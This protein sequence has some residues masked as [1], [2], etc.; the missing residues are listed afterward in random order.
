MI[1]SLLCARNALLTFASQTLKQHPKRVTSA[2]AAL[3]L[4]GGGGAFALAS[5]APDA[6]ELPVREVL[7][8][9]QALPL[10][11]ASD[12]LDVQAFK[13][14]RSEVTRSSDTADTLLKRLGVDDEAAA[15]FLR[16]DATARQVLLGRSGRNVTAET[17]E[18]NSLLK[19]SARWSAD[20]DG[21]FKRLVVEKTPQGF[22]S[23]IESAPL[24]ASTRLASGT[25]QTSLFAA[26]DDA[27]IPD[28][29]ATQVTEI[30]SGDID[31]HRSLRKGDR[32]SVV[33]E[34]LEG[35]GEPLR[36]GRVLS[37]EFVNGGKTFQAMWFQDPVAGSTPAADGA[38]AAD[39]RSK[40][41]YYTLDG[42]SLRRA[43]LA[44]P[45][46]FSRITSGFKMRF[47][48]LLH[49]W[50]AHQ[51]V[52]YAAPTGTAVRSVGDGVVDF[53]GVQNGYGNV[54]IL[55]HRNNYKTV[56]A[57]LS[58]INVHKGESVSQGQ[59]I[60]AVGATGWATG[61]HLH[62]EY[63]INNVYH[64]PLTIARE[65]NTVP[66]SASAKPAFARLASENR[67]ALSAA[68]TLQQTSA[69]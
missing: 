6:S 9:V 60:G 44:S 48:P 69:Q 52:D 68:A 3:L 51:G 64:D 61:P 47:H 4:G 56:Y 33:Y 53:A 43:Y 62:F 13:L 5:Y 45:V 2:I 63:R 24:S 17:S 29:I 54:I 11:V 28:S 12:A 19:L 35:D 50:K 30:F 49:V 14:F 20:S 67:V 7:E 36:T 38:S 46:E 41:G 42:Q 10:N 15:S 1:N 40:G 57:H 66:L 23:R 22:Q 21:N 65:N 16:A 37:V 59:N 34:T 55:Q 18:H 39:S 32:F 58:R 25:I 27:K 31:F 26:T 8:S